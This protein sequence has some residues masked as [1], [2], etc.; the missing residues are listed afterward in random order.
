MRRFYRRRYA[1][2]LDCLALDRTG[3]VL[4]IPH[5]GDED[6]L[7]AQSLEAWLESVVAAAAAGDMRYDAQSRFFPSYGSANFRFL[8][9]KK[10]VVLEG[11]APAS[12]FPPRVRTRRSSRALRRPR[13]RTRG[14]GRVVTVTGPVLRSA[15]ALVAA[16]LGKA[17]LP[18]LQ[19]HG[20]KREVEE[21]SQALKRQKSRP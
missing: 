14:D 11:S 3:R 12:S 9:S 4:D 10:Y 2:G 13:G 15:P 18:I 8:S 20:L 19:R 17:A 7:V 1:K 5:D 6:E 21:V 16:R